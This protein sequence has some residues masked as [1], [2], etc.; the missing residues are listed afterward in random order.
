MKIPM[1]P[2]GIET[3]T[4]LLVTQCLKQLINF[5][6]YDSE[7][8]KCEVIVVFKLVTPKEGIAIYCHC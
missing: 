4:F 6:G 5:H 8:F 7:W 2:S 3:A 1:T